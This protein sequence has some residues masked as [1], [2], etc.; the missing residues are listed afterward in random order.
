MKTDAE[1]RAQAKYDRDHKEQ[2]K[3]LHFKVNKEKY[4]KELEFYDNI[5]NKQSFFMYFLRLVMNE[6]TMTIKDAYK[7]WQNTK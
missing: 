3:Q 1:K 4:A 7:E 6:S 5:D 2:F